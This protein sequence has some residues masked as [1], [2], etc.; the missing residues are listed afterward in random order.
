MYGIIENLQS[1]KYAC[2][3]YQN[4]IETTALPRYRERERE[5]GMIMP[6]SLILA[7]NISLFHL[8]FL[9]RF[10][11]WEIYL[12]CMK[13]VIHIFSHFIKVLGLVENQS[14][15]YLGKIW[16]NHI[17]WPALVCPISLSCSIVISFVFVVL[18]WYLCSIWL[19]FCGMLS[20]PWI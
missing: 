4:N 13:W 20:G 1:L 8:A 16:K 5:R 19:L 12:T 17:P 3:E 2:L 10:K 14:D 15:W 18:F 7:K 6:L 11:N 9:S